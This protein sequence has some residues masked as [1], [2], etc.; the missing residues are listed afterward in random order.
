MGE[1]I[2]GMAQFEQFAQTFEIADEGTLFTGVFDTGTNN[3]KGHIEKDDGSEIAGE[4]LAIG[5]LEERTS[6]QGEDRGPL[7]AREYES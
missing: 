2:G 6:T 3:F 5:G 1:K 4:Q 7:Q